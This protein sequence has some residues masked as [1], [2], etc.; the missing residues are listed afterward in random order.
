MFGQL[1]GAY[2]YKDYVNELLLPLKAEGGSIQSGVSVARTA[3]ILHAALSA[4]KPEVCAVSYVRSGTHETKP[5][6]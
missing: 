4:I 6:V 5:S 1:D 2:F 3:R